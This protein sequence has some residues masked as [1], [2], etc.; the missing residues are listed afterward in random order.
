[1]ELEDWVCVSPVELQTK[2]YLTQLTGILQKQRLSQRVQVIGLGNLGD[3]LRLIGRPE[4]SE[5]V[6]QKALLL[7]K[8]FPNSSNFSNQIL[9]SLANTER[10]LYNQAKNQYQLTS[11]PIFHEQARVR[12]TSTLKKASQIYEKILGLNQSRNSTAI[13]VQVNQ[14]SLFLE[15]IEWERINSLVSKVL[16]D[17]YFLQLYVKQL[18]TT[19]F[20]ELPAIESIYTQIN[21][22]SSLIKISQDF[23]LNRI[24]TSENIK[25]LSVALSHANEAYR[26]A[27]KLNNIR[28]KSYALGIIGEIYSYQDKLNISEEYLSKA[29]LLAKSVK[30]YDIAYNFQQKLGALYQRIGSIKSAEKI[31]ADAINSLDIVRSSIMSINPEFQF[32]F[33]EKVEPV[34]R[35]YMELLL[36]QSQPD[37]KKII[38]IDKQLKLAELENFLQCGK[39]NITT[40]NNLKES[41]TLAPIIYFINSIK[42][43]E[44]IVKT[45]DGNFHH[46]TADK[47]L[48]SRN[49]NNLIKIIQSNHF[50][51]LEEKF[52]LTY[53]QTLYK[54]LIAPIKKYLPSSGEL[55]FVLDNYFQNVPIGMLHDGKDYLIKYYNI[56]IALSSELREV[57]AFKN[58]QLK[59][60]FAG[61]SESNP[62][63]KKHSELNRVSPL[64]EVEEEVALVKENTV[65]MK[66][67]LNERFTSKYFQQSILE[68]SEFPIVH[69]STH[70][71]FS[72]DPEKTFIL[73]WDKP[74]NIR[75]FD[76]ILRNQ[77]TI[78]L[79]ILSACQTANG[80]ARSAL[81]LAGTA[82]MAGAH[83]TLAT[84][85]LVDSSSTVE[86][87]GDFYKGL[88]KGFNKSEA[89]Q[90]AQ[91]TLLKNPKYA[92]PYYWAPFILL[93]R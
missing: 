12:A 29:L 38:Q 40:K 72:S 47:E 76:S 66:L 53:S 82:V 8:N 1:M 18:S 35:E 80:D 45:P 24:L 33:K 32:N 50:F 31:Y 48:V 87:M 36:K 23:E 10:T 90:Q 79:L 37:F 55:V 5:I 74:I 68:K 19:D 15:L 49:I 22:V 81:G 2:K 52:F 69:I 78:E 71:Q 60:V 44:I 75:E 73:A 43:V 62:N 70:G 20:R 34:Y 13:R 9:L 16:Q 88:K 11:E 3:V 92:H 39:L 30:A 61:I 17:R 67:L 93:G 91:L 14:L 64:P 25:P 57:I 54:E 28:A 26:K 41:T 4:G 21:F 84:L 46:H 89:L 65:N 77:N 85:W 6:L 86:V 51:N 83:N 59:V 63:L 42:Q 56:S 27:E 58:E 7:A